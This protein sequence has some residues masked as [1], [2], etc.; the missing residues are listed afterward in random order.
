M[1]ATKVSLK[2]A[3]TVLRAQ[4]M[5]EAERSGTKAVEGRWDDKFPRAKVS[6]LARRLGKLGRRKR[7][8][9]VDVLL[10]HLGRDTVWEDEDLIEFLSK[11]LARVPGRPLLRVPCQAK[12]EDG[13]DEK[14]CWVY[15]AGGTRGTAVETAKRKA[16]VFG[17]DAP[18]EKGR[19]PMVS[20]QNKVGRCRP[21]GTPV[22]LA[23]LL[24]APSVRW[25]TVSPASK[26]KQKEP[27]RR[28]RMLKESMAGLDAA[29]R[30]HNPRCVN[31]EHIF[32]QQAALNRGD[33]GEEL[34]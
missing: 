9:A 3:R 34:A 26:G 12:L 1:V 4:L 19:R 29:H 27:R 2:Q 25:K 21:R 16:N 7:L 20:V 17:L 11:L 24:L 33:G 10:E 14:D 30:C 15:K 6:T 13:V 8:N 18:A 32:L 22:P 31:P 28:V 5:A 23:R